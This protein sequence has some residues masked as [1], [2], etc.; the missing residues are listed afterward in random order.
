MDRIVESMLE[1]VRRVEELLSNGKII[2]ETRLSR[3]WQHLT[4]GTPFFM[5]SLQRGGMDDDMKKDAYEYLKDKVREKGYGFTELRGGFKEK[6]KKTKEVKYVVDELSLMVTLRKNYTKEENLKFFK[7]MIKIGEIDYS[8]DVANDKELG[9]QNSILYCDGDNFLGYVITDGSSGQKTTFEF[10]DSSDMD[11]KGEVGVK[12]L[13]FDIDVDIEFQYE[14]GS[15]KTLPM[16]VKKY[17]SS[18]AKGSHKGRKWSFKPTGASD[19]DDEDDDDDDDDKGKVN[20]NLFLYE[21]GDRRY[22]K[23]PKKDWWYNFGYRVL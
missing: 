6:N 16:I 2:T 15:D 3:V 23:H 22:P 21:M 1:K 11:K 20:E 7:D 13:K 14:K 10:V 4:D 19:D 5:L 9:S 17:F 8:K 18:L 12:S